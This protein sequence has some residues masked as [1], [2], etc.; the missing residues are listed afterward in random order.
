MPHPFVAPRRLVRLAPALRAAAAA[1]AALSLA[2]CA[3]QAPAAP[4]S[5]GPPAGAAPAA[6]GQA[7]TAAPP[8]PRLIRFGL[9]SLALSYMP[10]YLA[11]EQGI[12]AQHGLRA[13]FTIME[14]N[15]APAAMDRGETDIAGSGTSAVDYALQGG[16]V[17]I[18]MRLFDQSPWTLISRPD[19]QSAADLRGQTIATSAST[20]KLFAIAGVRHLGL[21][22]DQDVHFLETG[23]TS[24]SFTALLSGQIGAAVVTPPFDSKAKAQGYREL[25]FLGDLLGLPYVDLPTSKANLDKRPDVIKDTIRSL[26]ESMRWWR[27][28]PDDTVAAI[29]TKFDVAPSEAKDAYDTYT[30]IMT[31]TGDVDERSIRTYIDTASQVSGARPDVPIDS[32]VDT[33]LLHE[34]Q[35]EMGIK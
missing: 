2:A 11:D 15:I 19:I 32:L 1:L 13:E 21:V 7:A 25:L 23:G 4:A 34:V 10:M 5:G 17:R 14:T 6:S 33:R 29:A 26:F 12:F 8:E 28:R 9:P 24:A 31:T 3:A 20:P 18:F 27:D 22:P 30:R 16:D 35:A